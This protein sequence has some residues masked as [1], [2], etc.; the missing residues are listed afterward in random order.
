VQHGCLPLPGS[1]NPRHIQENSNIQDFHLSEA[2]M[3]Q[4]DAK[5]FSG[6]RFRLTEEHGLGFADEFDFTYDQCWH[7]Q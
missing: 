5:A 7:Q 1:K 4:I 2:E 6:T 3:Q